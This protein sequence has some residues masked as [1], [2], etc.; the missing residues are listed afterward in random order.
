MM[1]LY[2]VGHCLLILVLG[3]SAGAAKKLIGSRRL[4][5]ANLYMKRAGGVLLVILGAYIGVGA[6]F[7]ILGMGL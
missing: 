2:G 7:P 6:F 1:L 5:T 3:T 4:G